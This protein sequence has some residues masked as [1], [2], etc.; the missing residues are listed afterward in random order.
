MIRRVYNFSS[1]LL[2]TSQ[3]INN[4]SYIVHTIDIR[5]PISTLRIVLIQLSQSDI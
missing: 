2:E 1:Q 4:I 5:Q 3:V